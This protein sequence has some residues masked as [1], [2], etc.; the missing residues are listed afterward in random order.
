MLVGISGF[1]AVLTIAGLV[2]GSG[3][4]NGGTVY[5]VLP[6]I[7]PYMG[8]RLASGILII[9]GAFVG[10]YNVLMTLYRGERIAP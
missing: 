3:W 5:R 1:F 6:L 10:L 4:V 8:L 2:Q 9:L 7:A